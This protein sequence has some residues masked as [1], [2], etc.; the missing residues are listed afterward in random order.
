MCAKLGLSL[1]DRNIRPRV[2]EKKVL[3]KILED[4]ISEHVARMHESRNKY[5]LF[6]KSQRKG[7]QG[8]G[9]VVPVLS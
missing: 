4:K 3:R 5:I 6:G 7:Q 9:K 1:Y 8:K 2:P